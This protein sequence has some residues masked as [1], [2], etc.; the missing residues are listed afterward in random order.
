MFET[1]GSLKTDWAEKRDR[2]LHTD[3]TR[4]IQMMS[5][6]QKVINAMIMTKGRCVQCG[7]GKCTCQFLVSNRGRVLRT[8]P[9]DDTVKK[10]RRVVAEEMRNAPGREVRL[11]KRELWKMY[12]LGNKM[13]MITNVIRCD[14]SPIRW[15]RRWAKYVLK[16]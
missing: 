14:T 8:G 5:G 4:C 10:G 12:W 6:V 15:E 13:K 16:E 9:E 11:K 3:L 7:E 2:K 1:K